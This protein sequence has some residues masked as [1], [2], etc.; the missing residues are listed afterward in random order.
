MKAAALP[1]PVLLCIDVR[2]GDETYLEFITCNFWGSQPQRIN[3][4]SA[5]MTS[6]GM[7]MWARNST[8][9]AACGMFAYESHAEGNKGVVTLRT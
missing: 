2:G 5:G 1:T 6:Q 7:S 4:R 8:K 3:L 9:H